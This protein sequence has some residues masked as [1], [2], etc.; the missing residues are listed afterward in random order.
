MK[1][2]LIIGYVW[3]EETSGVGTR[4]M[5]LIELFLKN[6][7]QI[8][9]VS[10]SEK[11]E[12]SKDLTALGIKE[13]QI[14]LNCSSFDIFIKQL[15][16]NIV[17]FDR[18]LTEEQFGWRVTENCPNSLRI[19]DTEDLHFL[20]K[21]REECIHKNII[22]TKEK[23][24]NSELAIREIASILRC[25]LSLIISYFEF[26]LLKKPFNIQEE[27]LFHLPFL[28]DIINL[29]KIPKYEETTHFIFVGNFIHKP[30]VDSVLTL[31]NI[32]K[33]IRQQ[34]PNVELH[35]YGAYPTKQIQ[36][37]HN[38]KEGFIVKGYCEN[39]HEELKKA[40]VLLAPI[41]YGAGIKTKLLDAILNGT[42]SV[43]TKIGAEGMSFG[44]P[45][46]GIISELDHF[47][48]NAVRLYTNKELWQDSI[49]NGIKINELYDKNSLG[50]KLIS[51][52]QQLQS[53]LNLHR[54]H[55]FL[56]KILHYHNFKA[57]K[58]L[59]KWIEEKNR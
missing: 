54:T 15:N 11:T 30:N 7:F 18:F 13:H 9:F 56:G 32:W 37:L 41:R 35:I 2:I 52:I 45:W 25:D 50:Q 1:K 3:L 4:I 29:K 51:K 22:C 6:D 40:R 24:L 55:N 39:I 27:I 17:L 5:Q 31:K 57:T 58:Y 36:E 19:L 10:A 21:T 20:R 53:N 34:L 14:K 38:L 26:E 42:P 23:L 46:S 44:L 49:C 12:K 28:T 16:P 43:T 59:S 8:T 48:E 33:N 47:T